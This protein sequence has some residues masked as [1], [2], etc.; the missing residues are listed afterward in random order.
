LCGFA[1]A[2]NTCHGGAPR[3]FTTRFFC[4]FLPAPSCRGLAPPP[5]RRRSAHMTVTPPAAVLLARLPLLIRPEVTNKYLRLHSSIRFE[6]VDACP[7]NVAPPP[8]PGPLQWRAQP[9]NRATPSHLRAPTARARSRGKFATHYVAARRCTCQQ[10]STWR[11]GCRAAGGVPQAHPA[12]LHAAPA[13]RCRG[14]V[15]QLAR[16]G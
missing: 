16:I 3:T 2:R 10:R 14:G 9:P 7:P 11:D 4:K 1:R 12:P 13:L 5:R 6:L 15:P 8:P